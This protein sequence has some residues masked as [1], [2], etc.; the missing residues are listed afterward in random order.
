MNN[1]KST[2][3]LITVGTG[4]GGSKEATD[5]LAHGIL[6]SIE[7][8]GPHKVIF[9]G[10]RNSTYTIN[11]LKEQYLEKY[12]EE[13]DI[14]EFVE[15]EEIDSFKKYF[16]AIKSKILELEDDYNIVIDYTSG[17]KTMTMSAAFASMV[18]RKRLVFVSGER[19][20][21]IVVKG[22][23]E[24]N[25]QNLYLVY[26]DLMITKIKEL[27]NSNRFEAGKVL[28]DDITN[29]NENK[30]VYTQLFDAYSAFDCVDYVTALESF[31]VKEFCLKWPELE[32][33][34]QRNAKALNIINMEKHDQ[35]C[36][37]ILASMLNNARRRAEEHKYDDAI[38]RLYRSLE[39]IAQIRLNDYEIKTSDVDDK[40]LEGKVSDDYLY[41]LRLTRD[42]NSE[43][44]R[45]GLTQ[46]FILLNELGD[47]LGKFYMENEKLIQ[48]SLKYRNHSI[49]AHGLSSQTSEQYEE[50]R[51]IVFNAAHVLNAKIDNFINET[52]FPE[53]DV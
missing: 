31:D 9:F 51:D 6:K 15:I 37:Y 5:S 1:L 38:A 18:Y 36:F 10:S 24:I 34:F 32:R 7:N 3:M 21:G 27:F 20:D 16:T 52:I 47:D 49:L 14:S 28:V 40:L 43:K 44:I 39:L 22:T 45:M 11:S 4:I 50:F 35:K 8:F 12:S 42:K 23:E 25:S 13:F 33:T 2:A 48:N 30:D 41:D 26:D 46:D 53:F 19:V 29:T 17:T